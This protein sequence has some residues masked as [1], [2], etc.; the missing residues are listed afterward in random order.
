MFDRYVFKL[1]GAGRTIVLLALFSAV[2]AVLAVAQA[3]ALCSML[4]SIWSGAGLGSA[5]DGAGAL[6]LFG[7]GYLLIF[8]LCFAVRRLVEVAR[9][10]M[11][12]RF[13]AARAGGLRERAL[14][15]MV[16]DGARPGGAAGV[17]TAEG[18]DL[19]IEGAERVER[20]IEL[21]LGKAIEMVVTPLSLL[22]TL[23]SLDWVSGVIALI[24]YPVII[25]FMVLIG[26][27]AHAVAEERRVDQARLSNH[28]LDALRGLGTLRMFGRARGHAEAIFQVSERLRGTTMKTLRV[29]TLS[30]A[31]LDLCATFALAA[32]S[33]M[34][35]FRLVDGQMQL[36]PALMALV[37]TPDFFRPIRQFG[38]DYHA[39][40]DGKQAFALMRAV[41]DAPA[42]P[43]AALPDG[44]WG[45]DSVLE[46]RDVTVRYGESTRPALDGVSFTVRGF[47][48]VGVVG[49]SGSGKSTLMGVLAGFADPASGGLGVSWNV[50]KN[51]LFG[52]GPVFDH[53]ENGSFWDGSISRHSEADAE[54]ARGLNAPAW[55]RQVLY[56]PQRPYIFHATMAENIAFYRPDA[57]RDEIERA[58]DAMG[59]APLV[60]TLPKGLDTM[61]GD[62]AGARRLSGG[63]AQRV[64]LARAMVDRSRRVLLF[65]EPTAH[66][67]LET[68]LELKERMLPLM[69]G[70]LVIFATHR[71]HWLYNMDRALV[72]AH[73]RLVAD[74][75][76]RELMA[77]GV[78]ERSL[79]ATEGEVRDDR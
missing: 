73:G 68:E 45:T 59:L 57:P 16:E 18:L 77:S 58:A 48:R 37:L 51:G 52:D 4:V 11:L 46:A 9:E 42:R 21:S 40:L 75:D 60:A 65:D 3:W 29:A 70:R 30:A 17:G 27:Q 54:R 2:G 19:V 61:I 24:G 62:G 8:A 36:F 1:E 63:E 12:G 74:G 64:A 79:E 7:G 25:V 22:A 31:V 39:T 33:V 20:Y 53:S 35:G 55:Q 43:V 14:R 41:A 34:L 49:A 56:I 10:R 6:G 28:F 5:G 13:A 67:D 44:A 69:E 76:P 23:L 50:S 15:R 78:V 71:L 32:V 26:G 47:E 66:L 38:A 72:L